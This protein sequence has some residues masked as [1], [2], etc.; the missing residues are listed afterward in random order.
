MVTMGEVGTVAGAVYKPEAEMDPHAEPAQPVP[1]TVH[2]TE[3][4][5]LPVTFAENCCCPPA[6]TWAVGGE[7]E[8][9]TDAADSITMV[10][11]ADFVGAATEVAV[12]VAWAGLGTT[13]GAV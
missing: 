7:T 8:T 3:V 13:A 11:E 5:V 4:F 10:A 9:I 2:F 1:A 6:L 12:T